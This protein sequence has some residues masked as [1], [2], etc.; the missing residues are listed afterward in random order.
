MFRI[1]GNCTIRVN[2]DTMEVTDVIP[3][4][5]IEV[6]TED[7]EDEMLAQLEERGDA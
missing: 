3:E 7:W 2:I 6:A 4:P 5:N 1:T